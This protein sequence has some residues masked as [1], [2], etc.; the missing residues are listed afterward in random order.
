MAKLTSDEGSD[1]G[2]GFQSAESRVVRIAVWAA[3]YQ[4]EREHHQNSEC[5]VVAHAAKSVAQVLS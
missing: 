4:R 3:D 1:T 2:K 5:F